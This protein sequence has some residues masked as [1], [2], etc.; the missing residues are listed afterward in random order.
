MPFV[1]HFLNLN[2]HIH[3]AM[4]L[5][6]KD[7][8]PDQV[9]Y[10]LIQSIVPRPIAWVLSEH[11]NGKLN[12]A[13]FSFFNGVSG[14]P[15]LISL[16]IGQ[17]ED[18]THKDTWRNIEERSNFVIHIPH[19]EMAEAVTASAASLKTGESELELLNLKTTP[20]D[21]W[22]LPRLEMSRIALLCERYA[23]HITGDGPRGLILGKVLAAYID[24]GIATQEG[25]RLTINAKSLDPV[26]RLGG[27]DYATLGD[28][29]TVKH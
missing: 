10:T 23:I 26:A 24:D 2:H 20:V 4:I 14:N 3:P 19:R 11:E 27:N 21:G 15:P 13:P 25:K 22:P 18:G 6:F 29:L 5:S 17:K 28:I 16:A 9:Y 1:F 12:L 8:S 7:L